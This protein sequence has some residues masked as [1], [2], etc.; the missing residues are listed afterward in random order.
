MIVNSSYQYRKV[1]ATVH[2]KAM[3]LFYIYIY[4]GGGGELT[5][6]SGNSLGA[7]EGNVVK[8]VGEN[9]LRGKK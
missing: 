6:S 1:S 8:K 4:L 3:M 7:G 2:S 9:T 5:V